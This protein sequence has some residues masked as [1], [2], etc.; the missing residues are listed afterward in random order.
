[1]PVHPIT[2]LTVA[3]DGLFQKG[4]SPGEDGILA[5]CIVLFRAQENCK[6]VHGAILFV[7]AMA[8]LNSL[9][10]LGVTL[11]TKHLIDGA[12]VGRASALWTFGAT[13]VALIL[14][15]RI[16]AVFTAYVRT[17]LLRRFKS[18]CRVW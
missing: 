2:G 10:S 14:T 9:L 7:S 13:L 11:V 17:K 12:T 18:T 16:I 8:V 4:R 6:P 5:S 3:R 15:G 1:M